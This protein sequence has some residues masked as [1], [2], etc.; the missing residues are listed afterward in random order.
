MIKAR[1]GARSKGLRVWTLLSAEIKACEDIAG[2]RDFAW[3]L[4]IPYKT[5]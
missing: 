2:L 1:I 4:L 5:I 3:T